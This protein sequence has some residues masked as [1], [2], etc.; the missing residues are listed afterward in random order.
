MKRDM[1]LC[2]KILRCV[3]GFP[4]G[5][6]ALETADIPDTNNLEQDIV[7]YHVKLLSQAGFLDTGSSARGASL[8]KGLTWEGHE[9]LEKSRDDGIWE[10]AKKV[11]TEKTG[12]VA[13]ELLSTVMTDL[14]KKA[15]SG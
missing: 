13:I 10:K 12:G 1:D 4:H 6:F 2:R 14:L 9:F 5:I 3:E 11:V 7:N 15:I 8:I